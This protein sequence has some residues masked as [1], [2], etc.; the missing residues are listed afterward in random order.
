MFRRRKPE[1][2]ILRLYHLLWPAAG[3]KRAARY[4]WLRLIR[5]RE[6]PYSVAIG[7]AVGAAVCFT[8]FVGLQWGLAL[9]L[10]WMLRGSLLAATV[11][12]LVANPWT[13]PVIWWALLK[14][15]NTVL[16]RPGLAFP[17]GEISFN[18]LLSHSWDIFF[19]MVV[20][21]GIVAPLAGIFVYLFVHAII[22]RRLIK[23]RRGT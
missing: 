10:A 7:V 3:F 5:L 11:G 12:T 2:F 1:P 19:P 17:Q 23:L 22:S 13:Y 6:A 21:A 15:G 18:F 20:G 14:T 16:G 9:A 4:W 8:P